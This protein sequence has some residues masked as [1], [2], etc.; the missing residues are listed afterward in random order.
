MGRRVSGTVIGAVVLVAT[1][2][3]VPLGGPVASAVAAPPPGTITTVA[4]T[5][6][7]G[8]SGDGGPAASAEIFNPED[9]AVDAAGNIYI[10][11]DGNC[12]VRRVSAAGV[13]TTVAG[14]GTCGYSGDSGPAVD[15]ELNDADGVA[16]DASGNLYIGD[17]GNHVVRRV[18]AA[19]VIT[20]FAGTGVAG[21]TGNGGPAAD[22]ELNA[23]WG[24]RVDRSGDVYIADSG[25]NVVRKVSPNGTI[26]T[27]AGT[28]SSG[29]AGDGGPATDAELDSPFGLAVD[30][31]GNLFIADEANSVI[32]KVDLSGTITTVAGD[33]SSTHSG[34]GGP[35]T[36]AGLA[37]PYGVAVDA[38]GDLYI[39][40]YDGARVRE[41]D[42][43]TGIITTIAGTGI[44]GY[45]G[46]D[47]PATD[48]ELGG[49]VGLALDADGN[50]LIADFDS[51]VVRKVWQASP[52]GRGYFTVA[53]DGGIFNYGT[54]APFHGSAGAIHLNQPIVGMTTTP[55]HSGYWLVASDGGIFNF[56]DAGFYGSAGAI[57]L[58]Q[59]IVGMA[60]R[61]DG[62]GYWLVA[63]DG[64][65][66]NFGDAG[67]FGSAGALALNKPIVGMAA[68]PDGKGY[69]LVASD[70]GIFA[71]GDAGFHGSTGALTL[72]EPIVGMAATPSGHGYWLV[73]SDGG[74]FAYGDAGFYGSTGA[75]TLNKPV[76]GMASTPDGSGYWLV[77]SDG[78]IF[79]Y[80]DA[81]FYG[82][83][84]AIHLNQPIVG[85][86]AGR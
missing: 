7:S 72:N 82:S 43:A 74:I 17:T 36:A 1:G 79:A 50:L 85:M 26:T 80:G 31:A 62:K 76:V 59:P 10:G 45:S 22:A 58:N 86:A 25:A 42:G 78:G 46:D 70:G 57:H 6:T 14:N 75:L 39:S 21:S 24:V 48:A 9:V 29:Y 16:V 40:E 77:A 64:G 33:G 55:D 12:V 11:D 35:A 20:T 83:A 69:W 71:Y 23:P 60:A 13:I 30:P 68:T 28:G 63:S 47:G 38:S 15:A 53:S 61:P 5:G 44:P 8:Y 54:G 41:V 37:N 52:T 73:A 2:G 34:D 66:F 4:G 51:S 27:V 65:I 49:P 56:G 19:G 67:F 32:R 84:G 81:G 3:L 18:D